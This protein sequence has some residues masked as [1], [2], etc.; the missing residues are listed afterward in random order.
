MFF[1][2]HSLNLDSISSFLIKVCK[3]SFLNLTMKL[4]LDSVDIFSN[5]IM[6]CF[7]LIFASEF[8]SYIKDS[9]Y[10]L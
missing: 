2:S 9:R 8:L 10:V 5:D 4:T 1:V 3:S 7:S 6:H